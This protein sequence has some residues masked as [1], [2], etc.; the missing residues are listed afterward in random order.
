[1]VVAL[2]A[3]MFLFL[4]GIKFS[5]KEGLADYMSPQKT[6]SI[7]GI[8][9]IIVLL[10]HMRQYVTF[11]RTLFLNEAFYQF[12]FH[13]GQL[14]V[15]VFFFYSGYGIMQAIEKKKTAYVKTIPKRRLL[16]TFVHFAMTIDI[17]LV[18]NYFLGVTFPVKRI[19]LSFIGWSAV[20]NSAWFMFAI[21]I[22]YIATYLAFIVAKERKAAGAAAVTVMIAVY[23]AVMW[24]LK[25]TKN[26]WCFDTALCYPL[27][28]WY[29]LAKPR[30]DAQL[31]PSFKKWFAASLGLLAAFIGLHI[32]YRQDMT[33]NMYVFLVEAMVFAILIAVLSMR[34]SVDNKALRWCGSRVFSVYM[35]QRIPMMILAYFGVADY[36]YIFAAAAFAAT[37][38]IAELFDRFTAKTDK[39][40]RL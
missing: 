39:L 9:V 15:V 35:L 22:M 33:K 6:G 27:G 24:Y 16:K 10:S 40:M 11:D 32:F 20:G 2:A 4:Y 8:F 3:I 28:M 37:L 31:L 17:F 7:K 12:M 23:V 19:L 21:F 36:P 34:I 13:T 14:M 5:G 26:H 30:I 29:S 18:C 1:M 25:G 38:L